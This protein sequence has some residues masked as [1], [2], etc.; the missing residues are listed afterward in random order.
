M[1]FGNGEGI[2]AGT[3]AIFY[4][5]YN[6]VWANGNINFGSGLGS[7]GMMD[8]LNRFGLPCDTFGNLSLDPQFV[9]P[10]GPDNDPNT[11]SDN[12]Y[13]LAPTSPC[14]DAGD[15]ADPFTEEPEDNGDIVNIGIYGNTTEATTSL[16]GRPRFTSVPKDASGKYQQIFIFDF[17]SDAEGDGGH[18]SIMRSDPEVGGTMLDENSGVFSWT[19]ALTDSGKLRR[20]FVGITK[21]GLSS[22]TGWT[23]TVTADADADGMT[24]LWEAGNGLDPLTEDAMQDPDGDG[25]LNLMEFALEM[26]P[27]VRDVARAP[28]VTI[29][30][31]HAI[32]T[33]DRN[34]EATGLSFTVERSL[35]L[36]S[37]KSE[38]SDF[39]VLENTPSRLKVKLNEPIAS[40]PACFM[41]FS[42]GYSQN[43]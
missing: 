40:L 10:G 27:L 15:P 12:N 24:D 9:D 29:E 23:L 35:D 3:N 36:A 14:I 7:V 42:V 33:I 32:F 17:N 43:P 19:P 8:R 34:P 41:R 18:Y 39:T 31:E 11:I 26:K 16:P 6:N 30:D 5:L 4:F 13:H 21:N 1:V 37:W 2:S 38:A 20:F 22:V 28:Q 25:V